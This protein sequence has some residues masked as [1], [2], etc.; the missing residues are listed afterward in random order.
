GRGD[1]AYTIASNDTYPSWGYMAKNGGTT[2]WELWN[3]NTAAP[4]MNSGNHVMLLGDLIIWEYEYLAGIR[5]LKPGY[6]EIEFKPYPVDGLTFVNC[7]YNSV[8]GKIKS[9][10]KKENGRFIYEIEVPKGCKG[11]VL[12]PLA[13][14]SRK[15]ENVRAG[16][17]RFEVEM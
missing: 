15:S 6:K 9:N 4:S 7:S 8:N 13:D 11:T 2:I 12:L 1:L 16:S 5:P 14:G 17:H 3:G 10:W